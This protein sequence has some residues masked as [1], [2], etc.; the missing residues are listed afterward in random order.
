[1]SEEIDDKGTED[2]HFDVEE[3]HV[4]Y[5]V[6]GDEASLTKGDLELH[7]VESV[8]ADPIEGD[9]PAAAED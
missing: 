2:S 6:E 1:M 7:V 9:D 5:V 4:D 8:E 3:G